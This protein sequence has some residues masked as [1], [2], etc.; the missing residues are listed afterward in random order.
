[1]NCPLPATLAATLELLDGARALSSVQEVVWLDQSLHPHAPIY[2]VGMAWEIDGALDVE[3]LGRAVSD[4]AR[5]HDALRTVFDLVDGLPRQRVLAS[6]EVTM[7]VIDCRGDTLSP[8]QLH[9]AFVE[10]FGE[11]QWDTRLLCL[12]DERHVWLPR[13]HHLVN[14]GYGVAVFIHEVADAYNRL[15]AGDVCAEDAPSYIDFVDD[16]A[17]YL[18]SPRHERD[19]QFWR[20]HLADLP[21]PLLDAAPRAMVCRPASAWPGGCRAPHSTG[22]RTS[23]RATATALRTC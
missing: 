12:G 7:A 18:A 14:D 21:E 13:F 3:L 11:L 22:C 17:R 2:H 19:R 16:D 8:E 20:E 15:R 10:P 1:M 5:R 6:V 4:V 23:P 9:A